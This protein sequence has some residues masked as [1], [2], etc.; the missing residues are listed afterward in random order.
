MEEIE[1]SIERFEQ[2]TN[3]SRSSVL[4][5]VVLMLCMTSLSRHFVMIGVSVMGR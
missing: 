2:Y 3:W 5:R 1:S 4:G